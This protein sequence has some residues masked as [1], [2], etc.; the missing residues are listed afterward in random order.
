MSCTQSPTHVF[1]VADTPAVASFAIPPEPTP[2][3]ATDRVG[4]ARLAIA[5]WADTRGR[6]ALIAV[7]VLAILGLLAPWLAPYGPIE[8][9][10]L[11][12]LKSKPPSFAHPFGT[13]PLSRDVLSRMMYGARISLAVAFLSA[14]LSS[15]LGLV[16]GTIAGYIGGAVDSMLMRLVDAL[17]AI[18][19]VLLLI[20]VIALWG[21]VTAS[22]LVIVLGLTGWFGVSRLARGEAL[23]IKSRDFVVAARALGAGHLR[24]LV[25]HVIPHA[26][27]PVLVAATIAVSNAIVLEAGLSYLGYGVPTPAPS[28]GNIIQEGQD[29]LATTWWLS[30]LPGIALIV[31][32]LA[33]NTLADRLRA[34]LNPRQLP[35]P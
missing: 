28:W 23:A 21:H 11:L 2:P 19:R 26:I 6:A 30:I 20:T 13:D 31:S 12:R 4:V 16:Y 29:T 18:P 3:P 33:V 9:I 7:A 14:L 35:A 5:L 25:R 32:A 8:Q 10:D 24:I 27:G 1:A 17:L 22:S 15:V 34:A